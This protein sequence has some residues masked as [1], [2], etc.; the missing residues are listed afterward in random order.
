MASIH[1]HPGFHE[2]GH[3]HA[4]DRHPPAAIGLSLLRM[5][6][7]QRLAG[8]FALIALLWLAVFWAIS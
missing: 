1:P 4:G 6:V 5:S 7:W 8:A 2:H 3:H